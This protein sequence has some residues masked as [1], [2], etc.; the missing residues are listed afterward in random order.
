[1]KSKGA[2][3]EKEIER[4]VKL[5]E[6]EPDPLV[7]VLQKAQ[8][9][10]GYLPAEAIELIAEKLKVFPSQVYGVITFYSQF[11]MEPCGENMVRICHGTACHVRGAEKISTAVCDH[12]GIDEGETTQDGKFTV[13]RVF[14]VGSCSLAPIIRIN[15]HTYGRLTPRAAQSVVKKYE[16]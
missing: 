11:R 9:R 2:K 8:E 1:M 4:V 7:L 16:K 13:E 10:L 6:Q 3:L 14:C 15:E 5:Y 12:L